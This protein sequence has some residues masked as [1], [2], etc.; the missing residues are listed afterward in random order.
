MEYLKKAV[1]YLKDFLY[2][3]CLLAFGIFII[4]P[5][6]HLLTILTSPKSILGVLVIGPVVGLGSFLLNR[7]SFIAGSIGALATFLGLP[8]LPIFYPIAAG[9]GLNLLTGFFES[10]VVRIKTVHSSQAKLLEAQATGKE[11]HMVEHHRFDRDLKETDFNSIGPLAKSLYFNFKTAN[12]HAN[13]N[14]KP[15]DPNDLYS[16]P[17]GVGG[18]SEREIRFTRT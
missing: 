16:F 10:V 3:S 11:F 6:C 7:N 15:Y 4:I 12:K 17:A 1:L 5:I 2:T 14:R 8:S 18:L 9:L 13:S